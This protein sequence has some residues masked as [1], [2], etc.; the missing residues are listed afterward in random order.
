MKGIVTGMAGDDT[1][2]VVAVKTLK[3]MDHAFDIKLISFF[4]RECIG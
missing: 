1:E 4:Y 2:T 3:G